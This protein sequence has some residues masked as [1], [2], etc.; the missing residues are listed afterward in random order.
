MDSRK[1]TTTTTL[2]SGSLVV[3]VNKC[4]PTF[5]KRA[6]TVQ[7]VTKARKQEEKILSKI[8][9][10]QH[11]KLGREAHLVEILANFNPSD[12]DMV[13]EDLLFLYPGLVSKIPEKEKEKEMV[14]A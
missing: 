6:Q 1:S 3:Q 11:C 7:K 2:T 12:V 4:K 13:W 14:V 8:V 5:Y 10:F 9:Q